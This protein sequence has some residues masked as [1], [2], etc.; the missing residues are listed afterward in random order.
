MYKFLGISRMD[1]TAQDGKQVLGWKFWFAE[2]LEGESMGLRPFGVFF[3]DANVD[4][5]AGA[6]GGV[7]GFSPYLGKD[8]DVKF[9]RFGKVYSVQFPK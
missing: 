4:R 2:S 1:F 3:S 7:K 6:Y 5:I 8:C 9:N